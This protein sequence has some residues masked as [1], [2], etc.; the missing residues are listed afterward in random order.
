ML[1]NQNVLLCVDEKNVGRLVGAGQAQDGVLDEI[2]DHLHIVDMI[3]L[4]DKRFLLSAEG[5]RSC[6]LLVLLDLLLFLFKFINFD[7]SGAKLRALQLFLLMLLEVLI[8]VEI[9]DLF[10]DYLSPHGMLFVVLH[11]PLTSLLAACVQHL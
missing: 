9:L 3:Y 10:F 4:H 11:G 2:S 6:S 5:S 1:L 7:L 8:V